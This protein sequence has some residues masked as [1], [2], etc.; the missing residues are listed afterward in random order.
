[1]VALSVN[2]DLRHLSLSIFFLVDVAVLSSIT[3]VNA[4]FLKPIFDVAGRG[5]EN[6][7]GIL[8]LLVML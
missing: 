3:L 8:L 6:I 5:L 4:G 2:P 1:M 7:V